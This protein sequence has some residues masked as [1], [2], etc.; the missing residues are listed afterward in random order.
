VKYGFAVNVSADVGFRVTPFV[1]FGVTGRGAAVVG[2]LVTCRET[3]RVGPGVFPIEATR[4]GA[5]VGGFF[6]ADCLAAFVGD[7]VDLMSWRRCFCLD[8]FVND[9]VPEAERWLRLLG[10]DSPTTTEVLGS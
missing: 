10:G 3:A 4:T 2:F 1:G 8:V 5:E 7:G 9:E 6:G